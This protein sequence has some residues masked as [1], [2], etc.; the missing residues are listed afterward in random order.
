MSSMGSF[1]DA[2]RLQVL[3]RPGSWGSTLS[4][5]EADRILAWAAKVI[6]NR[7][8]RAHAEHL[9]HAF[10]SSEIAAEM[11]GR[12]FALAPRA[13]RKF[14]ENLFVNWGVLGG[15]ARFQVLE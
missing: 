10:N 12:L 5:D 6:P 14:I 1:R 8:I 11:A 13:R 2:F 3:R 4:I 9:H 7:E 15:S